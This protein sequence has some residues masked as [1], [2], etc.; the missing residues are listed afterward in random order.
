MDRIKINE[1]YDTEAN[2]HYCLIDLFQEEI[3]NLP[4]PESG[5]AVLC[6]LEAVERAN[7][8]LELAIKALQV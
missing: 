2:R 4:A 1:K 5:R 7:A 3:T 6:D 8:M